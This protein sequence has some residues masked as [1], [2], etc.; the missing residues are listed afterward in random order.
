[1]TSRYASGVYD[2]NVAYESGSLPNIKGVFL[3]EENSPTST[4]DILIT[5]DSAQDNC[6]IV[7]SLS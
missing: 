6:H 7:D 3:K 5:N 2:N 4:T 1:M